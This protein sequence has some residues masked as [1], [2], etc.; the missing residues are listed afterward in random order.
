MDTSKE[1]KDALKAIE[2]GHTAVVDGNEVT[3]YSED[4]FSCG[5]WGKEMLKLDAAA[6]CIVGSDEGEVVKEES[7]NATQMIERVLRG[8][9]PD[10]LVEDEDD[11]SEM[12]G[13]REIE[14]EEEKGEPEPDESD[15][16]IFDDRGRTSVSVEGKNIG[17][18]IDDD[19]AEIALKVWAKKNNY[20]PTVWRVSD[21]GNH[22]LATDWNWDDF[23]DP[24]DQKAM[25]SDF[26]HVMK[27]ISSEKRT[28]G[29][30]FDTK[31]AFYKAM[32]D[33]ELGAKIKPEWTL[34]TNPTDW[35]E[36]WIDQIHNFGD[37]EEEE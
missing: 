29:E 37:E 2:I 7:L 24:K 3:R 26:D 32:T 1:V 31:R 23:T 8:A 9:N 16:F 35:P 25:K 13:S 36:E 27:W 17:S 5:T 34:D 28:P 6:K 14:D 22:H 11:D 33:R 30:I 20:F 15:A 18:F 12:F 10:K 4:E 19:E 21:H